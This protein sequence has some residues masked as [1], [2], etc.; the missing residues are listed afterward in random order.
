[1]NI[2]LA[3]ARIENSNA[4]CEKEGRK[5]KWVDI[6][7]RGTVSQDQLAEFQIKGLVAGLMYDRLAGK[8]EKDT[9]CSSGITKRLPGLICTK[10]VWRSKNEWNTTFECFVN[11]NLK[12]GRIENDPSGGM[13]PDED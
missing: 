12:T 3:T 10:S 11:I 4:L 6:E 1:M 5:Y 13:C 8:I 7:G 9:G 2:S